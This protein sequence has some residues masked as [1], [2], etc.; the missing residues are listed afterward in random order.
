[1]SLPSVLVRPC[2]FRSIPPSK[3]TH[4]HTQTT[5]TPIFFS[6]FFFSLFLF[7][8]SR[9]ESS[10]STE[11]GEKPHTSFPGP[12]EPPSR[13]LQCDGRRRKRRSVAAHGIPAVPNLTI[14]IFFSRGTLFLCRILLRR[15][16]RDREQRSRPHSRS[17][18]S[19]CRVPPLIFF[20]P[21]PSLFPLRTGWESRKREGDRERGERRTHDRSRAALSIPRPRRPLSRT[22]EGSRGIY[23]CMRPSVSASRR[24]M[25]PP[26]Y[27]GCRYAR[28]ESVYANV[29][30]PAPKRP[31]DPFPIRPIFISAPG[32]ITVV[33]PPP[34]CRSRDDGTGGS[35]PGRG[36]ERS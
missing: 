4:A 23:A 27:R 28:R 36:P 22:V 11:P 31:H 35:G 20:F 6:L 3:C 12:S 21:D 26:S 5:P 1:M 18:E 15:P 2:Q 14:P 10:S 29:C 13:V 24:G 19:P 17:P 8:P 34:A 32:I 9:W 16:V 33:L 25:K 30:K 7:L